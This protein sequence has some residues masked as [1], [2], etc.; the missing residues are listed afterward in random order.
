MIAYF[1][2]GLLA[3]RIVRG[4][5]D[6]WLPPGERKQHAPLCNMSIGRE[7][8]GCDNWR[9]EC[10]YVPTKGRIRYNIASLLIATPVLWPLL[11]AGTFLFAER[12]TPALPKRMSKQER[13]TAAVAESPQL[14]S[15]MKELEDQYPL[16]LR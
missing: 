7:Y 5:V 11:L 8:R 3:A 2:I 6:L 13:L 4:K 16:T 1:V 14:Q 9:G 10:V 15:I 12:V